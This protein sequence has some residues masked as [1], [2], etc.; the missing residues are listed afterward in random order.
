MYNTPFCQQGNWFEMNESPN[1]DVT[2]V[3]N[4]PEEEPE[5]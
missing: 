2:P 5:K 1:R 4:P 3:G